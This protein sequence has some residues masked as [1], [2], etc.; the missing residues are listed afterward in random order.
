MSQIYF[1]GLPL[2][3]A[4]N[5][6]VENVAVLLEMLG[7]P[8]HARYHENIALTLG[9]IGDAYAVEPLIAYINSES[10]R[11]MSRSEYKG[12]V[13]AVVALGYLVN[14]SGSDRA[15]S[16]LS[17][18]ADPDRTMS[19]IGTEPAVGRKA[20]DLSKYAVFGLG[21]SG[22]PK[23]SERVRSLRDSM[24]RGASG[25][26]MGSSVEE[27]R[28]IYMQSLE[29]HEKVSRYGLRQYYNDTTKVR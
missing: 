29:E 24:A 16:Y 6:G 2:D 20:R 11:P 19:E 7:D 28:G 17:E 8:E 23:A 15:L 22:H 1:G 18:I 13:G 27:A 4:M 10:D 26:S 14:L 3:R 25:R 9:M 12:K 21:L 5:Y